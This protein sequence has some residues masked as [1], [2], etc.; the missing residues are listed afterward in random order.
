MAPCGKVS[1]L[2]RPSGNPFV[3][4]LRE[5]TAIILAG[6]LAT[7]LEDRGY[8]LDDDLWS[9]RVLLK[10]PEAIGKV[11]HDFLAAGADCITTAT[12]QASIPGFKKQGLDLEQARAQ[13]EVAVDLAV[14]ARDEFWSRPDNRPGRVKPL[15]AACVGPY[16][17]FLAD[18]SEYL[19][20][21]DIDDG[22]LADFHR[23][24]WHILAQGQADLLACETLPSFREAAVL[25]ELLDKTPDR[26]AWFSFSCRDGH[27]LCDGTPFV[28]AIELCAAHQRVAAVGVNCTAPEF[29]TPLLSAAR[30][31]TD[32]PLIAYP[33]SGEVFDPAGKT[34]RAGGSGQDLCE[35]TSEWLSLGVNVIGGC[36][37]IGPE[38]IA[39]FRRTLLD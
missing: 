19:G 33:N 39:N 23:E 24:R 2:A 7:T 27:H 21:Y 32:L 20:N 28:E 12:Y 9:A 16:G 18:G 8:D 37:R 17:A 10:D 29:I 3:P 4:V 26:W 14:N 31:V 13:L 30:P 6:G 15:V 22:G 38:A 11:H 25:L 5:Q 1:R 34:W 36:C 35:A